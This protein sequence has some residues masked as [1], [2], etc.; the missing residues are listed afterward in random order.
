MKKTLIYILVVLLLGL[1]IVVVVMDLNK[2]EEPIQAID[3]PI[4]KDTTSYEMNYKE[5]KQF[6]LDANAV[7]SLSVDKGK[8][9]VAYDS[10]ISLFNLKGEILKSFA[11]E[12]NVTSMKVT[13]DGF[14]YV[15]HRNFFVLLDE[16]G[17]PQYKSDEGDD[18]SVFTS[19]AFNNEFVFVA[20]AGNRKIVKY[21]LEGEKVGEFEGVYKSDND[22]KGFIIPSA[23]FDLVVNADYELWVV[24]PG[25]HALQ[26]YSHQGDLMNQWEKVNNRLDGFAGCCNPAQIAV[27]DD[28]RFVTAEK[29]NV[30][31][32]IYTKNGELESVVALPK[33]FK[34]K[35]A[36]DLAVDGKVIYALDF[37][38]KMIRVFEPKDNE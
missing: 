23:Y 32:K 17:N 2:D 1:V 26:H 5:T 24:N 19:L 3:L 27:F 14:V 25:I 30:R 4:V 22:T 20:D 13:P 31:I 18:K 38:Q 15:V 37:D 10:V 21:N 8:I 9:F 36:P 35:T 28:G 34:G 29:G 12:G 16:D 6:K 11:T 33:V 7:Y